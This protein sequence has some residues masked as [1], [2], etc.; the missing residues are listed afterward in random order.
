LE[1]SAERF[2][3]AFSPGLAG[4]PDPSLEVTP[5]WLTGCGFL[6]ISSFFFFEQLLPYLLFGQPLTK[7]SFLSSF[8]WA[9]FLGRLSTLVHRGECLVLLLF[10]LEYELSSR[11]RKVSRRWKAAF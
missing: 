4:W 1:T 9:I 6:T 11:L 3:P 8:F 5:L 2:F 10:L 7:F